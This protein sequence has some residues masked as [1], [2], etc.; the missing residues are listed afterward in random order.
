MTHPPA[1]DRVTVWVGLPIEGWNGRFQGAGGG[2]FSGGSP[3]GAVQPTALGFAAA[4]T[5]TGHEGGGG[6]FALDEKGRL[7][8]TLIRDNAHVGVHEMTRVGKA[9]TEAYYGAAPKYAYFNGCSTGGR[10]GLMEAQRYPQ[11]YDGVLSGCPAINWPKLH[12]EQLWGP[13]VMHEM[14][15]VVPPCKLE[16]ARLASIDAC[17]ANDGVTDGVIENPMQCDFNAKSL[18]GRE[19]EDCGAVT[20]K[21]AE[22]IAK[23]WLGPRRRD[24]SVLWYGLTYGAHFGGLERYNGE[25]VQ[26]MGITLDWFRYFL[27]ENP[28]WDWK[29]VSYGSYEAF[30]EASQERYGAVIGTDDPDLTEFRDRGGK[31]VLWHGLADPL[32]YPGGSIDYYERVVERMG[33]REK[34][35][36]FFRFFLAPGVAHCGRG[37]GPAPSGHFQALM[38]WIEQGEA[39]ETLDAVKRDGSRRVVR[40]RPLC[41]YPLTAVYDGSGSTDE[42]ESFSCR[43]G[44]SEPLP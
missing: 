37:D 15:H 7:D 32:I 4:S 2:G 23:I 30:W 39:P 36:E 31:I 20:A 3:R 26:P 10:Q 14:D 43:S 6:A 29:T 33:G 12:V 11:D 42:A 44:P 1:G 34:T 16:T 38:R 41:Q 13:L 8:W 19:R 27:N 40:T 5:D 18:I 24:G 21:D 25:E 22:V 17:D 28:E 35:S 9:L